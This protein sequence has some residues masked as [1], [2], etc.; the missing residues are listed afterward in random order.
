M[1]FFL[2]VFFLVG[3]ALTAQASAAT[4]RIVL[5]SRSDK[6]ALGIQ[7]LNIAGSG[8]LP[9]LHGFGGGRFSIQAVN[10]NDTPIDVRIYN[11]AEERVLL[12][13]SVTGGNQSVAREIFGEGF[14]ISVDSGGSTDPRD[15]DFR[16]TVEAIG[17]LSESLEHGMEAVSSTRP[18]TWFGPEQVSSSFLSAERKTTIN[19]LRRGVVRLHTPIAAQCRSYVGGSRI[20]S[21]GCTAWRVADNLF[22]TAW[23]CLPELQ[24]SCDHASITFGYSPR[25]VLQEKD[26]TEWGFATESC[27]TVEYAN[28]QLDFT[29]F[30]VSAREIEKWKNTPKLRVLPGDL[31]YPQTTTATQRTGDRLALIHFP[32]L[33]TCKDFDSRDA[34]PSL[35]GR[36]TA[37]YNRRKYQTSQKISAFD[38]SANAQCRAWVVQTGKN[39]DQPIYK[40]PSSGDPE[41]D[42]MAQ[43]GR[44]HK[45]EGSFCSR[46]L[47]DPAPRIG[48]LHR[49]ETCQGSSGAPLISLEPRPSSGLGRHG[50]VVGIHSGYYPKRNRGRRDFIGNFAIRMSK[51][52]ECLDMAAIRE[53]NKIVYSG[54]A[55]SKAVCKALHPRNAPHLKCNSLNDADCVFYFD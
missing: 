21:E 2:R 16:L 19:K 34:N 12:L 43:V 38:A 15:Y 35:P 22:A 4:T 26:S 13:R 41:F 10:Q 33:T 7:R 9:L 8:V 6:V 46:L 25:K 52:T 40:L 36:D 14:Y 54:S 20:D 31:S 51:I 42:V 5:D 44:N 1:I 17:F 39:S 18:P 53:T 24:D 30:R 23:H 3:L 45:P 28:D 47:P 48:L 11:L 37:A 27:T 55:S 50:T 32:A 29:L 49:C